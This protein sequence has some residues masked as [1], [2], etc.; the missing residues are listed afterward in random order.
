MTL[1]NNDSI[2]KQVRGL[3]LGD[4]AIAMQKQVDEFNSIKDVVAKEKDCLHD[5]THESLT[6]LSK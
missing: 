4:V 1:D 2:W 3:Q 6:D 5:H